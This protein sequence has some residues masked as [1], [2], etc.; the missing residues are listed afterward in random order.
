MKRLYQF[1]LL[2]LITGALSPVIVSAQKSTLSGYIKDAGNGEALIGVSVYIK[3]STTGVITNPY[4]FYSLSLNPGTYNIQ[5]SYVGYDVIDTMINLESTVNL[6]FE[7]KESIRQIQEVKI[8]SS[9]P[10][11]NVTSTKM[12]VVALSGKTINRIPVVFGEAD[13][14]KTL[15]MLPGV[16]AGDD[17]GS[18]MSVRGGARDQ[19]LILLD[20]ATVYNVS[21]LGNMLSVFNNDVIQ[22]VEFYKGNLPAH[23][24][25]RLSSVIDVRMM[26]GNKKQFG[27][28]GGIGSLSSRLTL[29]GPIKKDKGSFLISGR[30]AYFDLLSKAIHAINDTFPEVPYYFYDLN[31]KGNYSINSKNRIFVSGYFGK[32]VYEMK[33]ENSSYKDF[34]SWGNYTGT[35]RWN[36]IASEKI[37]T[38]LTLLV[39]N[40][41]YKFGNSFTYEKPKKKSEFNWDAD[42]VDYSF[43]YDAGI[44]LNNKNTIRAGLISTYHDFN[45]GKVI[46]RD[47][48]IK[49]N[50][51]FPANKA[52]EHA[53]YL[54]DE[55]KLSE[56]LTF[57]AGLRYSLFQNI[58]KAKIYKLNSEYQTID[59]LN[60][61]KGK[62]YNYYHSL[63]PRVAF[64]LRLN[65]NSSLKAGYSRTSQFIHVASN[66]STSSLIDIWVGSNPNIKPQLADLFSIGYFRN[67][68]NN[69]IETSVEAY[70]KNMY[71]QI[72]F[73][74][75]AIPQ[76]ND[77]IDE[78]FRHGIGRSY[79][80]ELFVKK[81]EG[82]LSGWISYTL[83]KSE[84]KIKDIQEKDWFLSTY[85]RRHD[86][87]MVAM[88][89][90][91]KRILLSA[92]FQLKSGRPFTSP[93]KRY[94][95]DGTVIPYFSKRNADRMP[96]YHRLDFGF[97][98][99]SK[100]KPGRRYHWETIVSIFD[101]YNRT[102]PVSISF[103]PDEKN[104]GITRAYKENFMGFMPSVTWNFSF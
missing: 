36:F 63:E 95:Y 103:R 68:L 41:N 43:K 35:L 1:L 49:Y 78:D 16:K 88:Y 48:T 19:N 7:L 90:L 75:F 22:N 34:F 47:D 14:L 54:S 80:M 69:T 70:Y 39:S 56:N 31:V 104:P 21:H 86:L 10:R 52:L 18:S 65:D 29:E 5:V 51:E 64:N 24:G 11:K 66:S 71:N 92:N 87:N 2:G 30:R 98:L 96:V 83:S 9:R 102:N 40:Y 93:V 25:G 13:I 33:S 82:I 37:F 74:E 50:F 44:Y 101:L 3:N 81:P 62:I 42:L 32:D 67:F 27:V 15:A 23:Y 28:S 77:R 57:E 91:S 94:L 79:G 60:Y 100:E 58:G 46:G 76:Y 20:E 99:K 12:S 59:T 45:P 8:K 6:N 73:R 38:N 61:A 89:N 17:G 85:D 72:E 4:G 97:T 84:R 55:Y 26:D 53:I